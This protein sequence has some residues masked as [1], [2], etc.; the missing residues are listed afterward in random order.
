MIS[1][2]RIHQRPDGRAIDEAVRRGVGMRSGVALTAALL[3]LIGSLETAA[4][5]ERAG[6]V[7]TLTGQAT[8]A[9]TAPAARSLPLRFKDDVFGRDR[10]ATGEQSLVRV[11]LGGKALVTVRELSTFTITEEAQ[12]AVIDLQSGKIGVAAARQLF[13][14]GERLEIRT[15]NAVAGIRGTLLIAE[16]LPNGDALFSV[17]SGIADI[18]RSG[19]GACATITKGERA[20]VSLTAIRPEPIPPGADPEAGLRPGGPQHTNSPSETSEDVAALAMQGATTIAALV[21]PPTPLPT[22]SSTPPVVTPPILPGNQSP[23]PSTS[24]PGAGTTP[25]HPSPSFQNGAFENG[26]SGWTATGA[27][28]VI[29]NLGSRMPPEGTSMAL[30]HTGVGAAASGTTSILSQSVGSDNLFFVRLT[31]KFLSAEFPTQA[32]RF[33]DTFTARLLGGSES[34]TIASASRNTSFD[35]ETGP[36]STEAVSG[37]NLPNI[38]AGSG[39]TPFEL[40]SRMVAFE[41]ASEKTLEFRIADAGD[42]AFDS[43]ALIDGVIVELDPP[44]YFVN[45]GGAYVSTPRTPLETLVGKTETFDSFMV[46]CCNSTVTLA[47]PLLHAVDSRLDV[48]FGVLNVMQGGR[49]QSSTTEPLVL[50]ER[51]AYNLGSWVGMFELAGGA[52][53]VDADTG[54]TLGIDQPL[55]LAGPLFESRGAQVTT[56]RAVK[57]D[58]ALLEA[59]MPL[60]R[61]TGGAALTT[62][63]ALIALPGKAQLTALGPLAGIDKSSITVKNGAALHLA[64]GSLVRVSGDLFALS[65][66]GRLTVLNG[67]LV[68]VSGGSVLNVGGA[69][70]AFGGSGGNVVKV[71][72]NLCPCTMF[73][74]VPVA[75]T[76]GA[77]ASNVQI[78]PGVIKNS[79]LGSITLS[80]NAALISVSGAKSK[81]SIGG[82]TTTAGVKR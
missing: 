26:L 49:V 66:G 61:M 64:G 81:V 13:Q 60:I 72:N 69:L 73:A 15:S 74:G 41:T 37:P 4:A 47:G 33:N 39:E 21:A 14:P 38:P 77:L 79:Q 65:N 12:R 9:R 35:V 22:T 51:G 50:L 24:P 23:S 6:V 5:Q 70:I 45:D 19:G 29:S 53:A 16:T 31:Y 58:T 67:A 57:L 56:L 68:R 7:T 43:A 8:V 2:Q 44:R 48:P 42:A 28:S 59:T 30:I 76:N 80:P 17:V 40:V 1:A 25:P 82:A 36:F 27:V 46:V 55:R 32:E 34:V 63:E 52:T 10:I 3:T 54:L 75:L 18:C 62:A 71:S 20:L 11:L 78:G